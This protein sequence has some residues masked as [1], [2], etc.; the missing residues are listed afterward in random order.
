MLKTLL[1]RINPVAEFV[2][3]KN[4]FVP[5]T[6]SSQLQFSVALMTSSKHMWCCW[7]AGETQT[8]TRVYQ[9]RNWKIWLPSGVLN[10]ASRRGGH[11]MKEFS[12]S[13]CVGWIISGLEV[14]KVNKKNVEEILTLEIRDAGMSQRCHLVAKYQA[15]QRKIRFCL[16]L[17]VLNTHHPT[18]A[19]TPLQKLAVKIL[20]L[21]KTT[22]EAVMS[23]L[24]RIFPQ[25]GLGF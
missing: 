23:K 6:L 3:G 17:I 1:M 8:R 15:K 4:L 11:D 12:K 10:N 7:S 2:P 22:S 19:W 14:F 13:Q 24:M 20:S 5:D 25:F 9:N 18:A 16:A 21:T